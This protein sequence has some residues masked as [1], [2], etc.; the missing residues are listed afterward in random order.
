METMQ[1]DKKADFLLFIATLLK[2]D[3]GNQ[4]HECP[5]IVSTVYDSY[6]RIRALD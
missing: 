3:I 4:D 2:E 5:H 6:F 1:G